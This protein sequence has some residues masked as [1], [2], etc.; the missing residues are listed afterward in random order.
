MSK[1][2]FISNGHGEDL[3]SLRIIQAFTAKNEGNSVFILPMIGE[4]KIFSKIKNINII[5]PQKET[6][7][8]GFVKSIGSLI[9]DVFSGILLLHFRQIRNASKHKYDL[10]VCVGD[11]FPFMLSFLF[12]KYVK[13]VLISTAKS[14]LF[15]P[16]FWIEFFFLKLAKAIVFTR[17]K[18]TADNLVARR[19]NALFLGNVM[20][21][22][23]NVKRRNKKEN[24]KFVLGILPGSR[25]EAYKNYEL[26][27]KVVLVLPA[28]WVVKVAVSSN[29]DQSKFMIAEKGEL[30]KMVDFEELLVDA[31]AVIGLAGTA[32]EQVI[33]MGIPLFTFT[34]YGPQTSKKRFVDQKKLL[35]D[36][37]EYICSQDSGRIAKLINQK[38]KDSEFINRVAN[39]GVK[40]MGK[41]GGAEQ[42]SN[43]LLNLL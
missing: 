41:S 34:G 17:D 26:I 3:I 32:N 35:G 27:K 28:D 12:L 21:D 29:M 20:M 19:V 16:H 15:E 4:G 30:L 13:I 42:I 43:E 7:S 6:S 5:G 14:D 33:G 39:E 1:I 18:I 24:D 23:L 36:L 10:V 8:G 11:F 25:V 9:K 22:G 38:V 40:V 37:P 2:L 31:D